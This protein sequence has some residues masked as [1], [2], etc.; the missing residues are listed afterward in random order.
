MTL[1]EMT[2]LG[3]QQVPTTNFRSESVWERRD[4]QRLLRDRVEALG[5]R[6]YVLAES[7]TAGTNPAS[8]SIS[9]VST[10]REI[11]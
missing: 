6:L 9:S 8:A 4:L 7:S 11:S 10:R 3:L 5:E 2:D 1:W